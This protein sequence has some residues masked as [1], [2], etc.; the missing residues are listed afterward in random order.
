MGCGASRIDDSSVV[1]LCRERRDLI[2]DAADL[3]YALASAHATYLRSLAE[4]GDAVQKFADE[5]L[6]TAPPQPRAPAIT[7]RTVGMSKSESGGSATPL[8]HSLS[9]DDDDEYHIHLSSDSA[10]EKFLKRSPGISPNYHYMRSSTAIP[11]M[12]SQNPYG[13]RFSVQRSL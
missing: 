1:S 10:S 5:E 6:A 2:R 11:S 8:S 4:I 12:V 9:P 3:R 7:L 13:P